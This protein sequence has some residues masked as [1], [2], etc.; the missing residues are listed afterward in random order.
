VGFTAIGRRATYRAELARLTRRFA[1]DI[2]AL[3]ESL[4]PDSP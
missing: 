2:F 1:D 3:V 4:G